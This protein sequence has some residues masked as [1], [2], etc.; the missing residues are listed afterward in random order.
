MDIDVI[1]PTEK[2][3]LPYIYRLFE[4]AIVYQKRNGYPVWRGYDK[5]VLTSE[6]DDK[7]QYK[8]VHHGEITY[9]FSLCYSDP[10][11]WREKER[12]DAVYLHRMVVNPKFKGQKRF[13]KILAWLQEHAANKKLWFIRMDTWAD[14]P[15]LIAYYQSFGFAVVGYC[16]TPDSE[17]LPLQQQNNEVVLLEMKL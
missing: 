16:K 8:L 5:A 6:M 10:V 1:I 11:I 7:R 14:N 15:S 2:A 4:E 13:G 9:A 3:D 17:A 12:G